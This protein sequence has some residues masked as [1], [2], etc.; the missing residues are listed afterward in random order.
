MSKFSLTVFD[1]YKEEY[2]KYLNSSAFFDHKYKWECLANF[3][4]NWDV[5]A[6]NF[7]E[8]YDDSLHHR[9]NTT[10]W[11]AHYYKPKA[12]MS[13]FIKLDEQRC[14]HMFEDLY[15]EDH[16]IEK[17]IDLFRMHC[18]DMLMDLQES[19][20]FLDNHFH[21]DGKMISTYLCFKYPNQYTLFDY[22]PFENFLK[23]IK[24][25]DIP[26]ENEIGRYFKL[27][28]VFLGLLTKDDELMSILSE[29]LYDTPYAEEPTTLFVYD[30]F[31]SCTHNDYQVL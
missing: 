18:D 31:Q 20:T 22:P 5:E 12:I 1:K 29:Q 25:S 26:G 9:S 21:H 8:M 15:N 27:A 24:A 3:Q 23:K 10:L 2:K 7:L 4:K 11:K 16:K 6:E 19:R 13:E 28:R 17:R 14:R 30:F